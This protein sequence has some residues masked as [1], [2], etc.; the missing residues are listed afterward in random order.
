MNLEREETQEPC[1]FPG[2]SIKPCS[3]TSSVGA[4]EL[5]TQSGQCE[6][7]ERKWE[8]GEVE[9]QGKRDNKS[10]GGANRRKELA[11]APIMTKERWQAVKGGTHTCSD[12][13]GSSAFPPT[14]G[15]K[16]ERLGNCNW[17]EHWDLINKNSLLCFDISGTCKTQSFVMVLH[18]RGEHIF[19]S[20]YPI[21][22]YP[23]AVG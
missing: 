16:E 11:K 7:K 8:G 21:P 13:G 18:Y 20:C 6:E 14:E 2:A 9:A 5:E 22:D 4:S 19:S 17:V 12:L 23:I 15:E 3:V 10:G 1:P